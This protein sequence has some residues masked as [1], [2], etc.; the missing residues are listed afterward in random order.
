MTAHR[1]D[2]ESVGLRRTL[3]VDPAAAGPTGFGVIET[4]GRTFRV[5]H[6]NSGA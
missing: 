1:S 4:D 3:G 2:A 5:L 6:S